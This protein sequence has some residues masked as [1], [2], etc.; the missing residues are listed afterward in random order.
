MAALWRKASPESAAEVMAF[1]CTEEAGRLYLLDLLRWNN[2]LTFRNIQEPLAAYRR[3]TILEIG[4]G[5]GTTAIQLAVQHNEVVAVEPNSFLRLF[6]QKRWEKVR[7][8]TGSIT[9]VDALPETGEFPLCV[10]VDVFEH[11]HPDTLPVTLRKICDLLTMHGRVYMHNCFNHT[12][13]YPM[14][15][16][17]SAKWPE[18]VKSAGLFRL[19]RQ[20]LT[21]P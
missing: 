15:Y 12:K 1:Y 5:L 14:H 19:S 10:A 11:L 20:W 2:S 6:A 3:T 18:Y 17:H 16:N 7:G 21:K 4:C 13:N 8:N 9:F